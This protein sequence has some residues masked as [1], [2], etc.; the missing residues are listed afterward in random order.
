MKNKKTLVDNKDHHENNALYYA[1]F[2]GHSGIVKELCHKEISYASSNNGVTPLH[3]AS[4]RGHFDTVKALLDYK[5]SVVKTVHP[6]EEN[7]YIDA[8]KKHKDDKTAAEVS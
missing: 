5:N 1:C 6:W 2:Y 7:F 3:I 8:R 4:M